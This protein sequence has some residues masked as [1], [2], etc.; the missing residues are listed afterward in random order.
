MMDKKE[1]NENKMSNNEGDD[2][3]EQ[4]SCIHRAMPHAAANTWTIVNKNRHESPLMRDRKHGLSSIKIA[5]I[6]SDCGAM[7]SVRTEW[8]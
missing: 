7:R 8:P 4:T 2:D 6:T 3:A 5:L 1:I